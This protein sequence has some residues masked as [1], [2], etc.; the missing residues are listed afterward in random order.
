MT[1]KNLLRDTLVMVMAG[2]QGERL[3][4]LT[5]DVAKPAVPFGG[6]YRLIDFTLSNCVNSNL[7]RIYLLT[8]Y[9]SASLDRHLRLGWNIFSAELGEYVYTVPPQQRTTDRW[10]R[11]TADAL[12]Q[13][14]YT[15]EQERP[16][17][18]LILSGDHVYKMDYRDLL[19]FHCEKGASLTIAGIDVPLHYAQSLGVMELDPDGR[20]VG[21]EEKP[22]RPR[23]IPSAPSHSVA[24]MGVYVFDTEA[25]VRGVVEDSR[26]DSAHDF[27]R[28]VIPGMVRDGARVYAYRRSAGSYWRDIGMIDTYWEAN[29][30]LLQPRPEFD[31]YD[32]SWPVRT[33]QRPCPPAKMV[34]DGGQAGSV[35][36][37]I[38]SSGCLISGGRVTNSVLSPAVHVCAGAEVVESVVMENAQIGAGAVV[39]RAIIDQDVVIPP[40]CRI[41]ADL[42]GDP[43]HFTITEGGVT[44]VPRGVPIE[45]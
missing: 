8:Q 17:R 20:V 45:G 44:V 38:L 21:F 27:G 34:A 30:D 9:K 35:L 24:S 22:Q 28:N 40:L 18:V 36:N 7:R 19:A 33:Y 42:G 29:M 31:L 37:S 32:P 41:G 14:I 25:L 2:G 6:I 3:Y 15:L 23:P 12:Y 13:N 4:P 39:H 43:R 5:Q 26:M 16:D 11:G 1:G 10:Y